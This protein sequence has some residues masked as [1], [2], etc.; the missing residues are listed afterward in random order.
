[1]EIITIVFAGLGLA[2]YVGDS[3]I[4]LYR[5]IKE[6]FKDGRLDA[7]EL[8]KIEQDSRLVVRGVLKFIGL[9]RSI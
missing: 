3:F 9:F 1:M 2:T 8:A 6:A 7:K 4:I 5:D